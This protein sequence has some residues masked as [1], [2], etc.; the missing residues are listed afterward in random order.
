MDEIYLRLESRSSYL[1]ALDQIY[2][3]FL[4]LLSTKVSYGHVSIE[5]SQT[6][7]RS[8]C[9]GLSNVSFS[10]KELTMRQNRRV[11]DT[12]TKGYNAH[13]RTQ[14]SYFDWFR[15]EDSD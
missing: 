11:E 10:Q 9:T 8:F 6:R 2:C 15:I 12:M 1:E 7:Y 3:D 14:I 13:L 5:L 4:S